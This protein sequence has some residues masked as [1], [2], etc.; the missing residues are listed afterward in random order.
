M[1]IL[2]YGFKFS[3]IRIRILKKLIKFFNELKLV[4]FEVADIILRSLGQL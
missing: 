1:R 2:G 4:L 3:E